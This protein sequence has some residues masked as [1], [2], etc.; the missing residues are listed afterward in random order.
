[1][2]PS[3]TV[4]LDRLFDGIE[5]AT[6][7]SSRDDPG[8]TYVGFKAGQPQYNHNQLDVGTFVLEAEG[9]RWAMDLGKDDYGLPGYFEN[10]VGGR[11]WTYYRNRA[12]G[13]NTLVLDPGASAEDQTVKAK[14]PISR[15]ETAPATGFA[16]GDLSSAYGK[17]PVQRGVRLDRDA[18]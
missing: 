4:P 17:R 18:G 6:L 1:T 9:V 8:A 2:G 11:R 10:N 7:R 5:A 15:F 16:I 3:P 12:E 13:H 14:A